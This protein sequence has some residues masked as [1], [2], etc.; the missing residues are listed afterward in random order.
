VFASAYEGALKAGDAVT[1]KRISTEY[2]GYIERYVAFYEQQSTALL[3][4]EI[5]QVLLLHASALNAA[6]FDSIAENLEARGYKFVALDRAL[7][8][9]S[10]CR[11]LGHPHATLVARRTGYVATSFIASRRS[12]ATP[13]T[14]S[15]M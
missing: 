2:D 3:G 12:A 5:R 13:A 7:E 1:A 6:A 10:Q 14:A 4:R 8:A 11:A 9:I 15:A